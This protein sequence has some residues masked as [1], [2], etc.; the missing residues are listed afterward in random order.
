[1]PL[2]DESRY[3][4]S[5]KGEPKEV[6]EIRKKIL[7][8]FNDIE[9]IED[10]HK[11]FR[12]G[13]EYQS[14]SSIASRF[15]EEF[16]CDAKAAAYARKNGN[17]AEYWKKQW[18]FKNLCATTTGTQCHAFAESMA[19]I[20]MGHPENITDDKKYSYIYDENWLIP[21]RE[22]EYAVLD[23]WDNKF[24]ANMYV[25]LPETRVFSS[26]N[27]ALP[28]FRENY[29]GTFD[30]L[31]YYKHPT[32]DSKSGCMIL[33]WKTNGDIYKEYSQTHM[34]MMKY[35]FNDLFD[36][37]YGAYTV[38]LNCYQIPLEDI[39]IKCIG[40]RIIWLKDDKTCEIIKVGDYT[41]RLR[42]YFL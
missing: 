5:V 10:G 34:K 28:K 27:P 7:D 2:R 13:E 16:D 4:I 14:V 30:L 25:V 29:A 11:Y 37:P 9:F 41:D 6:T 12:N 36:E 31:T 38:Q 24:P 26:P 17:T 35:P 39:G 19:W 32:D 1:M 20:H 18:R 42:K 22:K 21:T 33:D 3:N 15:E 8:S 23:F 40:K